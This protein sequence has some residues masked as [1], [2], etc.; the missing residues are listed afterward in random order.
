MKYISYQSDRLKGGDGM[1]A[2]RRIPLVA[3]LIRA[4]NRIPGYVAEYLG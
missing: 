4:R 2:K 3:S 1:R